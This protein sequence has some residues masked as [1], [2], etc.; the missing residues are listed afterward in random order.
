MNKIEDFKIRDCR[1]YIHNTYLSG[2]EAVIEYIRQKCSILKNELWWDYNYGLDYQ[3]LNELYIASWLEDVVSE[4]EF[5]KNI[6]N[7]QVIRENNQK[8]KVSLELELIND[9]NVDTSFNI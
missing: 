6:I 8:I 4:V 3:A 1:G 7:I 9:I 5:V 2:K